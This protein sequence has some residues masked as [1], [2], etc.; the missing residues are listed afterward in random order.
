MQF[1]LPMHPSSLI[2]CHSFYA[3]A[4][5]VES[6]KVT[7]A[8]AFRIF[9]GV[10]LT[11]TVIS[12][13]GGLVPDSTEAKTG[14]SSIVALFDRQSKIDSSN[15]SGMTLVLIQVKE[16]V[17]QLYKR[18]CE[19]PVRAGIKEGLLSSARFG[20]SMFCWYYAYAVSFYAGA[21]LIESGEVTFAEVLQ[22][23]YGLVFTVN[24]LYRSIDLVPDSTKAK[25]GASSIFALLDRK[26]K[27]DSSDNSRMTLD[28]L[29]EN[30]EFQLSKSTLIKK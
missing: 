24:T 22:V 23:F 11:A 20:F 21:R 19:G 9:Y 8:E 18:K 6:G 7:F 3:G 1:N 16:K 14:A 28:N 15:N 13:S 2:N 4:Q 10:S 29:K 17:V 12:Q 30:I 27:I 25:T 26:S 5:L